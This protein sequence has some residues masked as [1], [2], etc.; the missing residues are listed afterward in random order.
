[1]IIKDQINDDT[2]LPL[3]KLLD[4]KIFIIDDQISNLVLLEKI[5]R[6]EGYSNIVSTF[7]PELVAEQYKS[8]RPD[9]ILLDLEMPKMDGFQVLEQLNAIDYTLPPVILVTNE[10]DEDTRLQAVQNGVREF[11]TKPVNKLDVSLRV[12]TLLEV[13]L[14]KQAYAERVDFLEKTIRSIKGSIKATNT[15]LTK[16]DPRE[17]YICRSLRRKIDN[18][19]RKPGPLGPGFLLR[20]FGGNIKRCAHSILKSDEFV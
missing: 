3:E 7:N 11:L 13:R 9:L 18:Q 14:M 4:A 6:Q 19:K 8:F 15:I 17:I 5:L 1:M 2:V 12:Q 16:L 20:K 10:S